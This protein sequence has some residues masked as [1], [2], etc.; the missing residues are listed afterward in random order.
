MSVV[1]VQSTHPE[2][3]GPYVIID[4][5]HYDPTKHVLCT[6][7]GAPIGIEPG[8]GNGQGGPAIPD[9]WRSL[10][11]NAKIALAEKIAGADLEPADGETKTA[12]AE[13][14][15]ESEISVRAGA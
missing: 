12:A 7:D 3:Q 6:A 10:H 9:D 15:I 13:R 5:E 11:H 8:Q 14:V 1:Y 4:D 2:S